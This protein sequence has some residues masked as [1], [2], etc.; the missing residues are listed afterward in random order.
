MPVAPTAAPVAGIPPLSLTAFEGPLDLL[1]HL[2]RE[3]KIDIADIP[4]LQVTEHYLAHLRAMEAMNLT[5]A[6]EFLVMAATLLEI[7]SRLLLPKPPKEVGE[8]GEEGEDPRE[9]LVQRL[10]DYQRYKAF[11]ATLATWEDDRRQVFFRGQAAYGDLYELPVPY[12]EFSSGSLV[13]ALM[14]LLTELGSDSTDGKAH[15]GRAKV[16]LRLAM[17]TLW[18]KIQRA[19]EA[20]IIFDEC[21]ERPLIRFD[22][23]M[24]F[25]ALL[26][27]LRQSRVSAVQEEMLGEIRLTM[28]I[29]KAEDETGEAAQNDAEHTE[30]AE[31]QGGVAPTAEMEEEETE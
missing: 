9:E 13:K 16:T 10:L 27:L 30:H 20:G 5:V 29:Q 8:D 28:D 24:T 7:K 23:I 14:R 3:H 6:G 25:L 11:V 21:F 2:I 12:G 17:A 18:R 4:I 1:L 15:V 26:E 19:G 22:V 31:P